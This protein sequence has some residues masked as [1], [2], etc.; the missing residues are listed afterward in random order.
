[1]KMVLALIVSW[2]VGILQAPY[3]T[4]VSRLFYVKFY[5]FFHC[6]VIICSVLSTT[7]FPGP[8]FFPSLEREG[9]EEE[10]PWGRGCG[11]EEVK[12]KNA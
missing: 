2:G 11:K 7:S 10:R 1:M 3:T 12:R 9:R 4:G 5:A 6:I 8:L